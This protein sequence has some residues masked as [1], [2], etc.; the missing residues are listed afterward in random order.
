MPDRYGTTLDDIEELE[1]TR[2]EKVLALGLVVFLL[3]GAFWALGRLSELP[4]RPDYDAIRAQHGLDQVEQELRGRQAV[5]YRAE[6][7]VHTRQAE[8]DAA[9]REYEFRREEYRT[10]LNRGVDDP[11]LRARHEQARLAFERAQQNLELAEAVLAAARERLEPVEREHQ[12]RWGA[13][14]GAFDGAHRRYELA[15]AGVRFG[16]VVP[17][18]LGSVW[19]WQRMRRRRSRHLIIGTATLAAGTILMISLAGQYAWRFLQDLV[20]P[21]ISLIGSAVSILA[22][23]AIKRYV[24]SPERVVRARLRR[25]QC[26]HCGF[27]VP[28]GAGYARCPDCGGALHEACENCGAQRPVLAAH[29]PTCG[30]GRA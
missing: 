17:A 8:R 7:A 18:F 21:F 28:P 5:V 27:P 15:L 6:E 9:Q 19:L 1:T 10:A 24:F 26:P 3:I 29:C 23:I 12:E 13:A 14:Q 22:I 11:Q 16:F 30:A 2:A 25:H 4:R 20:T